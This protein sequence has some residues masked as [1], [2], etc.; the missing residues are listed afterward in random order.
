[1]LEDMVKHSGQLIPDPN[2]LILDDISQAAEK[3]DARQALDSALS[4]ENFSSRV[5]E[6]KTLFHSWIGE[7][8]R[9]K[10]ATL[11]KYYHFLE[12][13]DVLGLWQT[14]VEDNTYGVPLLTQ[15]FG[16]LMDLNLI[17]AF[18]FSSARNV[19]RL[20]EVGGGYG[21]L[22]EAAFNIFGPS[23]KYILVD[24][25]PAS[26]YYAKRYLS[27]ACPNALIGSYYEDGGD[28][29]DLDSYDIAI[30]PSWHFPKVNRS[31]YDICV[32]IESMQEMNQYH[33]DY[34][35][36]LFE[37]VSLNGATIYLSN[38]HDYYF[39][40]SFNY[41]KNWQK[42]FCTNTPRSWSMDHPTEIFRKTTQDCSLQNR[43]VDSIYKYRLSLENERGNLVTH[44]GFNRHKIISVLNGISEV[45]MAKLRRHVR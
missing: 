29:I 26:L 42:I 12:H 16:S 35:L 15:D 10:Q 20:L 13:C 8:E 4:G 38:A 18:S 44:T 6:M 40:G 41:P 19:T 1:M 28:Q 2:W 25:V 9:P 24:S 14:N 34:Y 22:A 5:S 3:Y 36:N 33:V 17:Y 21:R 43:A 11:T 32:N 27:H 37:S 39:R 23:M 7:A 30:V 31:R 45:V